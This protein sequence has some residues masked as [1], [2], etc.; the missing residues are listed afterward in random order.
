MTPN[1]LNLDQG[2]FLR[3]EHESN[4]M[5]MHQTPNW[6]W[7]FEWEHDPVKVDWLSRSATFI[8]T[9]HFLSNTFS[10]DLSLR[11]SVNS[12]Q[13]TGE[14]KKNYEVQARPA[15]GCQFSQRA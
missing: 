9:V 13:K 15:V 3:P 10:L 11:H 2:L 7:S 5:I 14:A 4:R 12:A 1:Y 6:S 8:S